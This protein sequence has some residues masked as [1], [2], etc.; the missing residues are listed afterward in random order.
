MSAQIKNNIRKYRQIKG[1][2]QGEAAKALGIT[3][4]YLSKIENNKFT[5]RSEL[6]IKICRYFKKDLGEMFYISYEGESIHDSQL[7]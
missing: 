4:T 1:V 6:M 2:N 7:L 3:R 5:P